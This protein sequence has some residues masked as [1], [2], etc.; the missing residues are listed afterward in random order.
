MRAI[1]DVDDP[2]YRRPAIRGIGA[3]LVVILLS[4]PRWSG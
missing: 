4:A 2:I 3:G 1:F